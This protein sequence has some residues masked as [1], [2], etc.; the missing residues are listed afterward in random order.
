M[1]V[2]LYFFCVTLSCLPCVNAVV[3]TVGGDKLIYKD[4]SELKAGD[5]CADRCCISSTSRQLLTVIMIFL[6][7]RG[8]PKQPHK[9]IHKGQKVEDS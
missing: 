3:C 6:L 9:T 4:N 7:P 5:R 8:K 1:C 2:S